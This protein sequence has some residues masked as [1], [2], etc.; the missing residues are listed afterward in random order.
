MKKRNAAIGGF[1]L[2]AVGAIGVGF[3]AMDDTLTI[4]GAVNSPDV[5][6]D[7]DFVKADSS[8]TPESQEKYVNSLVFSE[9]LDTL[10]ATVN[11]LDKLN[12]TA[13]LNLSIVNADEN[14]TGWTALCSFAVSISDTTHFSVETTFTSEQSLAVSDSYDFTVTVKCISVPTTPVK[15]TLTG[16]ITAKAKAQ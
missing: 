7:V 5:A 3:A 10:T 1:L 6:V 12:E 13:V 15:A 8:V 11:T 9:D 16:T 4:D 14:A 2:L